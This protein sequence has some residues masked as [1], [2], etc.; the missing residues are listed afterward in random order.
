VAGD[1]ELGA[2]FEQLRLQIL[3]QP[4]S[5]AS[6]REEVQAM[7]R[8]MRAELDRSDAQRVDLKHGLGALTDIEFLLQALLLQ[9]SM[10]QPAVALARDSSDII[11]ALC[12][13]NLL[14][15][16]QALALQTALAMLQALSLHCHLDLRPRISP[17][18]PE[19]QACLQQVCQVCLEQGFDFS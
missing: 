1:A 9:H 19:L 16:D 12:E 11:T 7:R 14:S 15:A 4:R 17:L 8:K 5:G 13:T 2:A 18:T 10:Q 3:R 6:L